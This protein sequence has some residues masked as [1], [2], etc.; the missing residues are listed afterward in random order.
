MRSLDNIR[1]F[2]ELK[3]YTFT[4]QRLGIHQK[5]FVTISSQNGHGITISAENPLYPF[6]TASVRLIAKDKLMAYDYMQA[7]GLNVPYTIAVTAAG[8]DGLHA[9]GLFED[10]RRY[11]VKPNRGAGSA[12]LTLDVGSLDT[13]QKAVD[14][15]LRVA[16]IVLVQ[17]QFVGEE[18]RLTIVDGKVRSA[19]LRQKPRVVGDG[20]SSI[21][22]LVTAENSLRQSLKH[23]QAPYPILDETLLDKKLLTSTTVPGAGEIVELSKSTMIRGGA[24]VFEILP[25]L[26]SSYV[27]N[28]E[29]AV[30][31]LGDGLLVVDLMMS[32]Y[33][34]PATDENYVFIEMNLSPALALYYSC[35]DGNHFAVVERYLGPMLERAIQGQR[36]EWPEP[37]AFSTIHR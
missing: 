27:Q 28:V 13:A 5:E 12:G 32:A 10:G 3:G 35:R 6:A 19:L 14:T 36:V 37:Y 21:R 22:E 7:A 17:S 30:R 15:A 9:A 4:A 23:T 18:V 8:Q 24:S 31:R 20:R 1:T 25:K 29:R 16:P 26:H 33:D 34:Q 2:L 11:I